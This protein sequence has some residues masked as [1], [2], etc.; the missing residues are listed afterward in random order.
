[1]EQGSSDLNGKIESYAWGIEDSDDDA[2]TI[3]LN[4][5]NTS[6]ATFTAS[7]LQEMLV[8]IHICLS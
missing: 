8:L 2:P 7:R 3:L 4:E 5:Q 6:I 1:M